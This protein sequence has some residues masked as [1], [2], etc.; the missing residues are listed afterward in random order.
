MLAYDG[1]RAGGF[2]PLVLLPAGRRVVLVVMRT[3]NLEVEAAARRV[4]RIRDAS[5]FVPLERLAVSPRCGFASVEQGNPFSWAAEQAKLERVGEVAARLSR[6][7]GRLGV[8]RRRAGVLGL[9]GW[10]AGP[11]AFRDRRERAGAA[12][13]MGQSD[14]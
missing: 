4:D 13:P 6:S 11:R 3:K 2:E 14:R 10:P 9:A 12:G 7:G 5:R 1:E 8:C